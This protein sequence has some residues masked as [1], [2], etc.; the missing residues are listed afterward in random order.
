MLLAEIDATGWVVIIGA[1]CVGVT[2][3]LTSVATLVIG[4]LERRRAAEREEAKIL[5]DAEA[6][7]K[8]E[9]VRVAAVGT[10][11]L[12]A[13]AA[14]KV[15]EVR[16]QAVE[17][18][19]QQ[20]AARVEAATKAEEVKTTLE[21][22]T[23]VQSELMDSLKKTGEETKKTGLL[24]HD[25]VNSASLVQLKLYAVAAQRI[26]DLTK[27]PADV[28]AAKVAEKLHHEH[29]AKAALATKK[30]EVRDNTSPGDKP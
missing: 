5:R 12:A 4:F 21:Q 27:D 2:G 28:E 9:E 7:K 13:T 26:A 17:L 15:E 6:A 30:A 25:L 3:V 11:R 18:K 22:A 29:E 14:T 23:V 20:E 16:V 24:T 19:E 10:A 1:G 8:V